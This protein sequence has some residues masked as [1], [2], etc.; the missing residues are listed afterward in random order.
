VH[1]TWSITP[2]S[3]IQEFFMHLPLL[4]VNA[5]D[6]PTMLLALCVDLSFESCHI[7]S[8]CSYVNCMPSWFSIEYC[9][10]RVCPSLVSFT[11]N[12]TV[13]D[14][15]IRCMFISILISGWISVFRITLFC[16]VIHLVTI[17]VL[18]QNL[19]CALFSS[20]SSPVTLSIILSI[21]FL[22]C[23]TSSVDRWTFTIRSNFT[24]KL[25]FLL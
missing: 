5:V 10:S 22:V 7:C 20:L 18:S 21:L 2:V 11:I 17:G 14:Y 9:W 6:S 15:V 3:R 25:S 1:V 13:R 19:D 8:I 23:C 4:E 24:H 12:D 16:C